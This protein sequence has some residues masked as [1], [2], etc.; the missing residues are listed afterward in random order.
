ML[1]FSKRLTTGQTAARVQITHY[2]TRFDLV[3]AAGEALANLCDWNAADDDFT[4]RATTLTRSEVEGYLR[5]LLYVG[6]SA[7]IEGGYEPNVRWDAKE[8]VADLAE[9]VVTR[10]YP[11]L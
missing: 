6:G 3:V 2:V 9:S 11:N 10:L 5:D 4:A 8:H 1:D 7:L